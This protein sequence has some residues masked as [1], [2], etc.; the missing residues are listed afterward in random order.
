MYKR[1]KKKQFFW[2]ILGGLSRFYPKKFFKRVP[3]KIIVELTNAC[4]LRC[5]VCP[6]HFAMKRQK[7]FMDLTL[8]KSFIDEFK[9]FKKK[10][11]IIMNFAGEPLLHE[12]AYKFVE[13]AHKNGH[14]TFISTNC[15]TLDKEL[16][17]K[18]IEAGLDSI[19]LCLEGLSKLSHESYRRGSKFEVI[20]K[21][22]EEFMR[23]KKLL[24]SNTPHVSIQTLLTSYSE[25][26]VDK[27]IDWAKKIGADDVNFKS[28]SM[29][30]FTT[31]EMKRK[32]NYFIPKEKKLRRKKS[33]LNKTICAS[34]L[35]QTVIYWNGDLGLCCIDFDDVLKIGNIKDGFLKLFKSD[36]TA[37]RR[38]A[39]FRKKYGLCKK[40][41]IG[42]ADFVSMSI[43]LK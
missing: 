4:N 39:A 16:S 17:K 3:G 37:R 21:N 7:G 24:K 8:F 27:I 22:I 19:H 30:S 26:E 41:S 43:K 40:C 25:K 12:D 42:N 38:K 6:T 18:L 2:N 33:N 29:G 5:P 23:I 34:I 9:E 13:Y 1:L 15:T 28:F 36:T 20:K 32:Y 11:K 10:P 31:E 35:Y 14:E